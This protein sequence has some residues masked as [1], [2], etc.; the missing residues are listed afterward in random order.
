MGGFG[1][2]KTPDCQTLG[3]PDLNLGSRLSLPEYAPDTI[4]GAVFSFVTVSLTYEAAG[5]GW[6]WGVLVGRGSFSSGWRWSHTHSRLEQQTVCPVIEDWWSSHIS[7]SHPSL[8]HCS[9]GHLEVSLFDFSRG[10]FAMQMRS[11]ESL[12]VPINHAPV[13]ALVHKCFI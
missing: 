13:V 5:G 11:Y 6:R 8:L 2:G 3:I 7:R 4:A 12:E 10:H 1:G 9:R